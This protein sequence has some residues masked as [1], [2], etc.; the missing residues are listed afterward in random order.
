MTTFVHCIH[1]CYNLQ[2]KTFLH[3][4]CADD[5]S[6]F[7]A[8][9]D[10]NFLNDAVGSELTPLNLWFK[11]NKLS[12]NMHKTNFVLLNPYR[13][14]FSVYNFKLCIDGNPAMPVSHV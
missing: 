10:F 6:I 14:H 1:L 12:L 4:L 8:N 3:S 13:K 9:Y 7:Y 5:T 11:A 2:Y